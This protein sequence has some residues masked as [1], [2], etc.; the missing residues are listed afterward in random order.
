MNT[1]L[2]DSATEA[3]R[4]QWRAWMSTPPASCRCWI[5]HLISLDLN[6]FIG[7]QSVMS[8]S[9]AGYTRMCTECLLVLCWQSDHC[10]RSALWTSEQLH[11]QTE[12]LPVQLTG[13]HV[14]SSNTQFFDSSNAVSLKKTVKFSPNLTTKV[15][16]WKVLTVGFTT[17]S[18]A[19]ISHRDSRLWWHMVGQ[20]QWPLPQVHVSSDANP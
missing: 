17:A 1:G 7:N 13:K 3:A 12:R 5:H 19:H 2:P 15:L 6:F 9:L 4:T 14:M 8:V 10:P 18:S 20:E 16:W 11:G